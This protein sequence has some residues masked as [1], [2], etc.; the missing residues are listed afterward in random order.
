MCLQ[1]SDVDKQ[2]IM[3]KKSRWY[4]C[5]WL[6]FNVLSRGGGGGGGGDLKFSHMKDRKFTSN[7]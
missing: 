7:S 3:Y 4:V 1:E 5:M 2:M 6:D